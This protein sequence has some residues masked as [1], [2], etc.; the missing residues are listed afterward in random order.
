MNPAGLDALYAELEERGGWFGSFGD[1]DE[2]GRGRV[3][4]QRDRDGGRAIENSEIFRS[5]DGRSWV[6]YADRQCAACARVV[7]VFRRLDGIEV[8]LAAEVNGVASLLLTPSYARF[9]HDDRC[10]LG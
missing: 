10:P 8:D 4:V 5:A 3:A 2:D 6:I 1:R 9:Q 7:E